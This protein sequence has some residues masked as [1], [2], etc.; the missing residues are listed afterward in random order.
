LSSDIRCTVEDATERNASTA[1]I[2][3][4]LRGTRVFTGTLLILI[5]AFPSK[6][7]AASEGNL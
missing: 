5:M 4:I 2:A 7:P 1:A 3:Q 6:C